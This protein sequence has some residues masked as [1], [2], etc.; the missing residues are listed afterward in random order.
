MIRNSHRTKKALILLLVLIGTGLA[1]T[2]SLF[3]QPYVLEVDLPDTALIGSHYDLRLPVYIKNPQDSVGAFDFRIVAN[4]PGIV[5]LKDTIIR[6]GALTSYWELLGSRFLDSA[7]TIYRAYGVADWITFPKEQPALAPQTGETPLF[8]LLA[9]VI[10]ESDSS[11]SRVT[12]S[13]QYEL[14]EDFIV[15]D[16]VG[17]TIG[18]KL[19]DLIDTVYYACELWYADSCVSWVEVS[20]PPADSIEYWDYQQAWLDSTISYLKPG[21]IDVGFHLCGD[22]IGND[23]KVNLADITSMIALVYLEGAAALY[24]WSADVDGS[25][26]G[27]VNLADITRLI[28]FVY[29]SHR[30]L[31]CY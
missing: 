31:D 26:D 23:D 16:E 17:F 18:T 11:N 12:L 24:D 5:H 8:Y 19:V 20:G 25:H 2:G 1:P 22:L 4:P 9:D 21:A 6:E 28:D 29:I 27:K 3:S 13:I 15:S 7:H 10:P 30:P 14:P